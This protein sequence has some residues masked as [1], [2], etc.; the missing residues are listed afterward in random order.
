M[1]TTGNL[2]TEPRGMRY[3]DSGERDRSQALGRWL[4]ESA[5]DDIAEFRWQTGY[6]TVDGLPVLLPLLERLLAAQRLV[7]A[8]VGSNDPPTYAADV[9]ELVRALGIPRVYAALGVVS[10]AAG[11]FHP[12]VYHF[13]RA[14]G[15]VT[16][17]VGSANLTWQGVSGTNVEAG[18]LLDSR[19]GDP[20]VVLDSIGAAVDA[21]FTIARAGVSFVQS[22]ADVDELTAKGILADAPLPA[23]PRR[24]ATGPGGQVVREGLARLV[25]LFTVPKFARTL[26]AVPAVPAVTAVPALPAPAPAPPAPALAAQPAAPRGDYP[27]YFLFAPGVA[28]PTIGAAAVSGAVLPGAASGLIVR[29]NRD[30]GRHLQGRTGTANFSIPIATLNT[31]RFG[32]YAGNFV[33]PRAEFEL[34]MR[35]MGAAGETRHPAADTNIMGYGYAPGEPGHQDIRMLIPAA[36][37][38]FTH[39]IA[40]AGSVP[41]GVGSDALLEWPTLAEPEFRLTLLEPGSALALSAAQVFNSA[42]AAGQLVSGGACWLPNGFSPPW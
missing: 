9:K 42:A 37:K 18:L 12:K 24:E 6:F 26:P 13:T 23:P 28:V 38:H 33:R 2:F 32:L 27:A 16:A 29:F 8:L 11:L 35:F 25:P 21:W 40:A 14:D 39:A 17:Y 31:F 30:N 41:P 36:L 5:S 19:D 7:R 3:I 22:D 1:A 15:S 34:L 4:E 10:F 20:A